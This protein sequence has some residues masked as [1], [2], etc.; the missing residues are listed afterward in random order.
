M[1]WR[2]GKYQVLMENV[3]NPTTKPKTKPVRAPFQVRERMVSPART[4]SKVGARNTPK[5]VTIKWNSDCDC[6]RA[7]HRLSAI[8]IA[9]STRVES[10]PTLTSFRS[11]D[12]GLMRRK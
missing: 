1:S 12:C 11:D 9:P 5:A 3:V 6:V 8:T 2:E 4:G 10:L 7:I